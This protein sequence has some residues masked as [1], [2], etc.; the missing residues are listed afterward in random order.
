MPESVA[1][2]GENI[3]PTRK[4]SQT[5][6]SKIKQRNPQNKFNPVYICSEYNYII[7]QAF[8]TQ[9]ADVCILAQQ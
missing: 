2:R 8:R 9:R 5:G 1:G 3:W 4:S 7:W 6:L